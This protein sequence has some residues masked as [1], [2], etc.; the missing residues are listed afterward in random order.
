MPDEIYSVKINRRDGALEITGPDK[1]WIAQ[2]LERLAVVYEEEP[3]GGALA[4]GSVSNDDGGA[5]RETS[6]KPKPD[7]TTTAA[8][9][10]RMPRRRGKG[11]G[12]RGKRND[13]LAQKLTAEIR[14]S[15]EAYVDERRSNF[16]DGPSQMAIIAAFLQTELGW[17]A[18]TPND[19]YTIYD[20]MGWPGPHP[21]AALDNAKARKNYFTSAGPGRYRLSHTGE[22]FGRHEAKAKPPPEE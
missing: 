9:A 22:R 18:V 12:S 11:S 7:K 4:Q 20:V 14:A 3:V 21:K 10:A 2:Q 16:S 13:E 8:G 6:S 5:T 1:T 19:L 17:D 15:L